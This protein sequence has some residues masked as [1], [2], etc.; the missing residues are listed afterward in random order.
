MLEK[1]YYLQN[2]TGPR[3]K[4]RGAGK[5]VTQVYMKKPEMPPV[6]F[7]GSLCKI[8]AI[9]CSKI[10]DV[11][12]IDVHDHRTWNF[13]YFRKIVR[14]LLHSTRNVTKWGKG[15]QFRGCRITVGGQKLTTMSQALFKTVHLFPKD[16]RFE[17]GGA[18]LVSC[19]RRHLILLHPCTER[20]SSQNGK[21]CWQKYLPTSGKLSIIN[22]LKENA[23]DYWSHL[24]IENNLKVEKRY[25]TS[26]TSTTFPPP[27]K[28]LGVRVE[29]NMPK[30]SKAIV[31][32]AL[33]PGRCLLHYKGIE[34]DQTIFPH[35]S[36]KREVCSES[37]TKLSSI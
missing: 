33:C 12:G 2:N 32:L 14:F 16:L 8:H 22:Y 7:A 37:M 21:I 9:L 31:M 36:G 11:H 26:K 13:F 19:P 3:Q 18:K 15:A 29:T 35:H 34:N 4:T 17:H 27:Q 10:A 1:F 23:V 24:T 28:T 6:T 20:L 25:T 5:E 30:N